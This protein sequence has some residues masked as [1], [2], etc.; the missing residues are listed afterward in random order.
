VTVSEDTSKNEF[1]LLVFWSNG[2]CQ[3]GRV[4]TEEI[5]DSPKDREVFFEAQLARTWNWIA[6]ALVIGSLLALFFYGWSLKLPN[7]ARQAVATETYA[8]ISINLFGAL[9]ALSVLLRTMHFCLS[10]MEEII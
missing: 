2:I 10:S 5:S 1:A 7:G 6:P 3:L 8:R 9:A 4:K